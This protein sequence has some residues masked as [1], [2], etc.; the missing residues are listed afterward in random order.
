MELNDQKQQ[1]YLATQDAK[2]KWNEAVHTF[3]VAFGWDHQPVGFT[4]LWVKVQDGVKYAVDEGTAVDLELGFPEK[5][6]VV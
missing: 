5:E 6:G 4:W 1:M 2:R 3:L